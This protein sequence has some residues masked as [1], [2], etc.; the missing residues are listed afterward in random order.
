MRSIRAARAILEEALLGDFERRLAE[1]DLSPVTARG[2]RHRHYGELDCLFDETV[3]RD[4]VGEQWDQMVRLA[5]SL[6]NR[7]AARDCGGT[8]GQRRSR[9]SPRQGI[10]RLRPHREDHLHPALHLGRKTPANRS[11]A[12]Q[13]RRGAAFPGPVVILRQSGRIPGTA[14]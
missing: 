2:Y 8:A 6:K 12:A 14:T 13:P 7:L 5:V 1:Q 11:V 4:L 9:R 10:D 3:S